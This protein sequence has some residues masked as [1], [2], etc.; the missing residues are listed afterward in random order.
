MVQETINGISFLD[1]RGHEKK[2]RP[3]I[4][5]GTARTAAL[6]SVNRFAG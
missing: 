1:S 3:T 5:D 2:S 4:L 6:R